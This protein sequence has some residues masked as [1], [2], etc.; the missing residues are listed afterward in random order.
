MHVDHENQSF[1]LVIYREIT[2]A[3]SEIHTSH[4]NTLYAQDIKFLNAELGGTYS[5]YWV[6]RG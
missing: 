4:R 6:L 5:N 3:F 2:S 1:G